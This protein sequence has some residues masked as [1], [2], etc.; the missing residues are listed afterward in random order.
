MSG[1]V[2]KIKGISKLYHATGCTTKQIKEAQNALGIDFPEE[3]IDYVKEYGAIS[4]YGTEWT[5]LNVGGY[6][7]VVEVT[8]QERD[9]NSSFPS[10]CFV[11][12]NQGI[13]GLITIMNEKGW[14]FTLQYDK[15]EPLCDSLVEYLDI[16][17]A[18][19]K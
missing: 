13:D 9:M 15:K 7:N 4:F 17:I 8:K 3:F 19:K 2:E 14:V 11:I 1:I 6:L 12:E 16:C 5:G 10:D 18:R